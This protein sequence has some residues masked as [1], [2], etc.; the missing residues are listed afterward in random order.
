MHA[1]MQNISELTGKIDFESQ[2]INNVVVHFLS[3]NAFNVYCMLLNAILQRLK[4]SKYVK[5]QYSITR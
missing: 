3:S 2:K 4:L 1:H 5:I